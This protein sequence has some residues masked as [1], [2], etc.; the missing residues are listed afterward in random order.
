MNPTNIGLGSFVNSDRII[1]IINPES[2]PVKRLVQDARE[3]GTL[4]DATYGRRTRGILVMDQG[5]IVLSPL[6]P[7]T[8]VDRSISRGCKN[9]IATE[10]D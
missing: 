10:E 1:A 8:I 2:A 7:S 5:Q 3:R 9:K 4:V 6:Q